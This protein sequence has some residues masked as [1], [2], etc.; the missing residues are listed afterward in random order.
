MSTEREEF[1]AEWRAKFA[2]T[3]DENGLVHDGTFIG[4]L[5]IE[6]FLRLELMRAYDE[7]LL[8]VSLTMLY[9]TGAE[10]PLTGVLDMPGVTRVAPER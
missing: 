1:I 2:A 7:E 4:P 6:Q 9:G 3:A 10:E 5:T 8:D